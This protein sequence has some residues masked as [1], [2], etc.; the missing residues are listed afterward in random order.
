MASAIAA[1]EATEATSTSNMNRPQLKHVG[2]SSMEVDAQVERF[3]MRL[4]QAEREEKALEAAMAG[5]RKEVDEKV[6]AMAALEADSDEDDVQGE[7]A[8]DTMDFDLPDMVNANAGGRRMS[9][10]ERERVEA[11][12]QAAIKK[13]RDEE[14]TRRA[15]LVRSSDLEAMA[16][17]LCA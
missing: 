16:E 10:V 8:D 12:E 9:A 13:V 14:L 4:S 2:S 15:S 11:A 5:A 1:A 17:A 7:A 3:G 6:Q